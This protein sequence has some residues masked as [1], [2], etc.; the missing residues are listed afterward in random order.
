MSNKF[1]DNVT[2]L[3]AKTLN[4]FEDDLRNT[5]LPI[6]NAIAD[7]GLD[8]YLQYVID[9]ERFEKA[10]KIGYTFI[11]IPNSS[12][13]G[14]SGKYISIS[15]GGR[16][17]PLFWNN[18]DVNPTIANTVEFATVN[19]TKYLVADKQY[20]IKCFAKLTNNYQFIITEMFKVNPVYPATETEFGGIKAWVDRSTLY[21]STE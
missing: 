4:G 12:S 5:G 14:T 2:L 15:H 17:D 3:D 10:L 21:L 19:D 1:T 13:K 9:D 20:I 7:H 8:G 18:T 11:I 16:R 6:F